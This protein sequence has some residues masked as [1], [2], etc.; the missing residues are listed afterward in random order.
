MSKAKVDIK[1]ITDEMIEEKRKALASELEKEAK[2]KKSGSSPA[3]DFLTK[4]SDE[5]KK[6]ID[7]KVSY[8]AIARTIESVYSV[9]VS[10]QTIRAFAHNIL[11]V[12]KKVVK[13]SKESEKATPK[14][15]EKEDN[16]TSRK[17]GK[18]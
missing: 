5:I 12:P 2:S 4:I 8:R 11:K 13:S 14:E 7:D 1:S 9:S 3:T 15:D 17:K 16:D 18:W 6:S 10:E